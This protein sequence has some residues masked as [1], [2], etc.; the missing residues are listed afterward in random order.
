MKKCK[1]CEKIC[2]LSTCPYID[3]C[4]KC[5]MLFCEEVTGGK[6][7]EEPDWSSSRIPTNRKITK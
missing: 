2:E 1:K 3:I 5:L 7:K 4:D 6:N